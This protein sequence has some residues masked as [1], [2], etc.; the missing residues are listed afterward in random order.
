M[1]KRVILVLFLSNEVLADARTTLYDFRFWHAPEHTRIVIDTE[2]GINY[3]L[4]QNKRQITLSIKNAKLLTRTYKNLFFRGKRVQRVNVLRKHQTFNIFF[5]THQKYRLNSF[6]LKPS[7]RYPYHRLVI[8]LHD[9]THK[10]NKKNKINQRF[11]N[12]TII[13]IDAGHGGE[14]SGALGHKK[15]QEK[16]ITLSIAKKLAEKINQNQKMHAILTRNG[17]YY[18]KLNQRIQLAQKHKADLFISIHADSVKRRGAH[19]ASV[20]T[21]SD[22]GKISALA[23]QL[24]KT[25]NTLDVFGDSRTHLEDKYLNQILWDFSR[26]DRD[27][28]S[29]KLATHILSHMKKIGTLHKKHP[30]KANF[31]VLKTPAIPSV[32]VETAFISNPQEERRLNNL[33]A[34]YKI[35]NAI[36][37]ALLDYYQ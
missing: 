29:Q 17:D 36:Y 37:Q 5:K 22:K 16:H 8:D 1:F 7:K 12:K 24:E 3:K 18:I 33:E 11:E 19:G 27:I 25:Q 4:S 23:K 30:Q 9:K 14:D 26:K 31:V 10:K 15:T 20:Y 2:Q 21:L 32:L 6:Q 13:L 35:A 28:Q 34:Q